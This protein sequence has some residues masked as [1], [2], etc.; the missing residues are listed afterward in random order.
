MASTT[1]A[2]ARYPAAAPRSSAATAPQ[3]P[4][5]ADLFDDDNAEDAPGSVYDSAAD[6]STADSSGSEAATALLGDEGAGIGGGAAGRAN[7]GRAG[8]DAADWWSAGGGMGCGR[9]RSRPRSGRE[10]GPVPIERAATTVSAIEAPA[11]AHV[12]PTGAATQSIG[13]LKHGEGD[14]RVCF[15]FASSEGCAAGA[16]CSFCHLP[17][18]VAGGGPRKSK[19]KRMRLQRLYAQNSALLASSA[20]AK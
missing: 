7:M 2:V 17:H 10:L 4:R 20:S 15:F 19:S 3:R 13:S 6:D 14:C 5:W 18:A 11:S 8:G 9:L 1:S 16:C 12:E